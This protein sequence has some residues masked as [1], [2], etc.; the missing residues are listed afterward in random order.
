VRIPLRVHWTL[1]LALPWFAAAFAP[2]VA[3]QGAGRAESLVIGVLL[4]IAL[5]VSVALHE[6]SH[7]VVGVRLGAHIKGI[8]LM[9]LGGV[10]ELSRAPTRPS[11]EVLMAIAGPI[12]SLL[13]AGVLWLAA[14][15]L[16]TTAPI[17]AGE[18]GAGVAF[19]AL[20]LLA[21][22]NLV[23]GLFNLVPAFPLDGGRVLR[24]LLSWRIGAR[25]ATRVASV[26]GRVVAVL[27]AVAGVI[28][29]LV[30]VTLVAAFVYLAA[31][32]EARFDR[33]QETLG[34]VRVSSLME[35]APRVDAAATISEAIER[36]ARFGGD[37]LLVERESVTVGLLTAERL[38]RVPPMT[39]PHLRADAM[40]DALPEPIRPD[41]TAAD[42]LRRMVEQETPVLPVGD[43]ER[44]IGVV[45]LS[46]LRRH[47]ERLEDEE[48]AQAHGTPHPVG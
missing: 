27:L 24:A 47:V 39:R 1:A 42:V 17:N 5:F 41:V 7:T 37:V 11:G 35:L 36:L 22:V 46:D 30:F 40:M 44:V 10:S 18:A 20:A 13:I 45:R 3:H 21:R 33:M 9:L 31:S 23:V 29:G 16:R 38:L 48:A 25:R 26:I 34:Q 15:A 12:A 28:N 6:L 43:G 32:S 2:S 14:L 19:T 4:A 8:T